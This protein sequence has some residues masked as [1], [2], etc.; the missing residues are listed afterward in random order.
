[1][2]SD[3]PIRPSGVAQK[4]SSNLISGPYYFYAT[5]SYQKAAKLMKPLRKVVI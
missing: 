5:L 1:L 2:S 4:V 3:F